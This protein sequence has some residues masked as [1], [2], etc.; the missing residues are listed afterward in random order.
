MQMGHPINTPEGEKSVQKWVKRMQESPDRVPP[1]VR[2]KQA[3]GSW[4]IFGGNARYTAA[5]RLGL[6]TL[7]TIDYYPR[8]ILKAM[9]TDAK[10][11]AAQ[12]VNPVVVNTNKINTVNDV[13]QSISDIATQ[14]KSSGGAAG[15]AP[16][17]KPLSDP[18]VEEIAKTLGTQ[19]DDVV[20][21]LRG[22][23]LS[24]EEVRASGMV[25][26][27]MKQNLQDAADSFAVTGDEEALKKA[28]AQFQVTHSAIL[29]SHTEL[30]QSMRILQ[31]A[32]IQS[33]K[34]FG[35]ELTANVE[36]LNANGITGAQ[37][38]Q[39]IDAAGIDA[40][41]KTAVSASEL[42][43]DIWK[44]LLYSSVL[45]NPRTNIVNV[46]SGSTLNPINTMATHW[47]REKFGSGYI[48][49]GET[50][51]MTNA[52]TEAWMNG[53]RSAIQSKNDL[54]WW[55]AIRSMK[56]TPVFGEPAEAATKGPAITG[57]NVGTIAST[58]GQ[59]YIPN[60]VKSGMSK[61]A[62][63]DPANADRSIDLA[64]RGAFSETALGPLVDGIGELVH[65]PLAMLR[66][67]D[68]FSKSVNFDMAVRA[69]ALRHGFINAGD[70]KAAIQA[71]VQ[72]ALGDRTLK[73]KD[74]AMKLADVNTYTNELKYG[75]PRILDHPVV[76]T[77]VLF[78]KTPANIFKYNLA[79]TPMGVALSDVRADLLAGGTRRE[80]AMARMALGSAFMGGVAAFAGSDTV[81]ITGRGP[82]NPH[83]RAMWEKDNQPYSIKVTNPVSGKSTWI[84]MNR[85]EPFGTWLGVAADMVH[86]QSDVNPEDLGEVAAAA[87]ASFA[88]NF[89]NKTFTY[90]AFELLNV[91]NVKNYE[92]VDSLEKNLEQYMAN[93]AAQFAVPAIASG[94]AKAID[95]DIHTSKVHGD[96]VQTMLNRIKAR[97]PNWSK[98]LPTEL[99]AYGNPRQ[100]EGGWATQLFS[101]FSIKS[102]NDDP[103][104]KE[105]A[106]V[107]ANFPSVPYQT[108]G[109][110]LTPQERHRW[111]LIAG[112]A[113]FGDGNMQQQLT[114]L[115]ESDEYKT[116]PTDAFRAK[117]LEGIGR[118]RLAQAKV[119]LLEENEDLFNRIYGTKMKKAEELV[120]PLSIGGESVGST[121]EILNY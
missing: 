43:S 47:L 81:S 35:T 121:Q 5:Q 55:G 90:S 88:R 86:M 6:P 111:Q 114:A 28:Y 110:A 24:V 117:L 50:A 103:N 73:I 119:H 46:L 91:L 27:K 67:G 25:Y 53:V 95:P 33:T 96:Y 84:G 69:A 66:A 18:Y 15:L 59:N 31:D 98:D 120:G 68:Y 102:F 19:Q 97:T 72:A 101:P 34:T 70:D 51:A 52:F 14:L 89:T 12:A 61:L 104:V 17:Q 77:Q 79:H 92:E 112:K 74:E 109:V 58:V 56:N 8:D 48:K 4:K 99:D 118:A 21:R 71:G 2:E 106:R 82:D 45:S 116:A 63:I 9:G 44:E 41:T 30:G 87:T 40:V 49:S 32:E 107:M 1:I 64:F 7:E 78:Y 76:K 29:G 57:E 42:G 93:K 38:K 65:S 62:G 11:E 108:D 16:G 60:S 113:N 80:A 54:G 75:V 94:A 105:I 39:A 20:N 115:R 36:A 13:N 83:T 100:V 26:A 10:T 22:N 23:G 37:L 3:D 85:I